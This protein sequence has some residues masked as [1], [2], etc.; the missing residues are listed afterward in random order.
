MQLD[1]W[2]YDLPA[3]RIAVRPAEPRDHSRLMVVPREGG[4]VLHRRFYEIESL[5]RP[6][7]L[8]V[9]NDTRVW[10]G[11]IFATRPSGGRVEL[12]VLSRRGERVV[13]LARP[14]RKLKPGDVLDLG[15]GLTAAVEGAGT[16][17]GEVLL[18]FSE[19][20]ED[21]LARVGHVPLPPYIQRPDDRADKERYQTVYAKEAGSAAAPTAGL[22]FTEE[23][24]GRL[25]A[26][27]V[28][29]GT[30]T[31]HVGIG[32]FRPLEES[33]VARGT[34][35]REQWRIRPDL[36]ELIY[37]TRRRGGRVVAVGT[38]SARTL[39]SATPPGS[40][41]PV[42]GAGETDLFIKPPYEPRC[43]DGLITNFHLPRSSLLMLVATL[44]SRDRL[45]QAYEVAIRESYRFYSYGDAMLLL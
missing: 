6:G 4:E 44:C 20:L 9:A 33:D 22:H 26:A 28:G 8:L 42:P 35:H 40:R 17:P 31:L 16:A 15:D 3:D 37:E 24:L 36:C 39:E 21:V 43:I 19:P 29:F 12:L 25:A 34:L 27:G 45:F 14:A 2:D 1:A 18:T 13:A 10:A 41:V 5:L 30:V 7:D 11:R 32:T 38:T 23:L